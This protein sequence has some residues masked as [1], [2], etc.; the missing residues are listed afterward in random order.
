MTHKRNEHKR[1]FDEM[2]SPPSPAVILPP[3][4]T[5]PPPVMQ[6]P[7][8]DMNKFDEMESP[9]SPQLAVMPPSGVTQPPAVIQSPL[10]DINTAAITCS[11]SPDDSDQPLSPEEVEAYRD[12]LDTLKAQQMEW[13]YLQDTA[14]A[15]NVC[16]RKLL[17]E[18]TAV[19]IHLILSL[20]SS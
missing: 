2:E 14:S 17:S 3:E 7:L 15:Q 18:F 12:A 10:Q 11:G 19:A 8:Q 6:T 20:S 1:K 9:P 4:V 13:D 16:I 5:Q